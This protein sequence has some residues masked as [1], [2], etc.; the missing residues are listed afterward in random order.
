MASRSRAAVSRRR[1]LTL[2]AALAAGAVPSAAATAASRRRIRPGSSPRDVAGERARRTAPG[3]RVADPAEIEK[4]KKY[5][6]DLLKVIRSFDLPPGSPMGFAF[7][8]LKARRSRGS[9]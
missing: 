2:A 4:Q 9:E 8:P 5:T 6:A 3:G 7:V 1:F